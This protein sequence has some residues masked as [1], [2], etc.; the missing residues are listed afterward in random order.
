V[1][2]RANPPQVAYT[3][4]LI[5]SASRD[6]LFGA[7]LN[8]WDFADSGET[9]V[10]LGHA[11]VPAGGHSTGLAQNPVLRRQV[12]A[13]ALAYRGH[14]REARTL[15]E[16]G[17]TLGEIHSV[18]AGIALLGSSV[19]ESVDAT[20]G[21]WLRRGSFW[22]PG[23]WP[24]GG[25]P[26]PMAWGLSWWSARGDTLAL[27]EYGRRADSAQRATPHPIWKENAQYLA[28]AARAYL[29]LA[30]G[31]TAAAL[32]FFQRP[33]DFIFPWV[34][35]T[36][37][38]IL[39]RMGRDAEAL[40]LFEEAY[41]LLSFWGPTR[42]LARLEAAKS[43]ERL[44]QSKRAREH[45]QFVVDVWRHADPGL[46]PYMREARVGLERLATER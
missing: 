14:L 31:D 32:R 7:M 21:R 1:I 22:P 38:E 9:L 19:P 42:V 29:V 44:G 6:Q 43:A 18:P 36:E 27:A 26:G 15:I 3:D 20:F 37:A 10:R 13:A 25:P 16:R 8:S 45:Y 12:L 17:L 23:E 39:S 41:P 11:L 46:E 5:G 34:R 30:R 2:F 28:E 24:A 40:Q 4:S 33:N 35:V